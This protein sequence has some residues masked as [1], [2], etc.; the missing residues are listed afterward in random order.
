[1]SDFIKLHWQGRG[2]GHMLG[3]HHGMV[4][5][6]TLANMSQKKKSIICEIRIWSLIELVFKQAIG[7]CYNLQKRYTRNDNDKGI[8]EAKDTNLLITFNILMV[9]PCIRII[10]RISTTAFISRNTTGQFMLSPGYSRF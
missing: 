1:M 6:K 5:R 2:K 7:E 3:D 4:L 10:K 9:T 8:F